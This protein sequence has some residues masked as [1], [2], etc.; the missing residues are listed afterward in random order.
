[1]YTEDSLR[2]FRSSQWRKFRKY[3]IAERGNK[4]QRCGLYRFGKGEL[5]V[6]HLRYDRLKR[7]IPEDVQ[8]IC[9]HCHEFADQERHEYN[10]ARSLNALEEARFYGWAQARYGD[11]WERMDPH[12]LEEEF[13]EFLEMV[14][15]E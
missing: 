10:Q 3:I 9:R 5:H 15:D 4:C 7:E 2:Y 11:D 12:E 13:D 8:V 1:M 14:R 6:H